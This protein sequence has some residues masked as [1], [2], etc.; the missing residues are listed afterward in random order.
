MTIIDIITL[1]KEILIIIS[2]LIG[3]YLSMR[4][5]RKYTPVVSFKITPI[6]ANQFVILKIEIENKSKVLLKVKHK[7]I[8]FKIIS[9]KINTI[10]NLTEVVDISGANLICKSTTSL[11]PGEVVRIDRLYQCEPTELLQGIIQFNAKFSWL[12]RLLVNTSNEKWT[13]TF[14]LNRTSKD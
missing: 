11:Y 10:G 6:W 4:L 9:H 5:F 1:I 7:G 12:D 3:A 2:I 8:K 13:S 14:I